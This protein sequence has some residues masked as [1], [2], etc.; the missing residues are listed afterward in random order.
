M[1]TVEE[2]V[3]ILE[4]TVAVQSIMIDGLAKESSMVKMFADMRADMA[5]EFAELRKDMQNGFTQSNNNVTA[6]DTRLAKVETR[7]L[8]M[9]GTAKMYLAIGSALVLGLGGVFAIFKYMFPPI[10]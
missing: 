2:R 7:I 6:L 4:K 5:R 10:H 9:P 8:F 1:A 3:S